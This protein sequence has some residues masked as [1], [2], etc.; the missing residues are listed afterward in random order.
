MKKYYDFKDGL[1]EA[2]FFYSYS[3]HAPIRA[4]FKQENG[5]LINAYSDEVKNFEYASV[6]TR[7]KYGVGVKLTTECD[8]DSFGAPLV[9]LSDDIKMDENGVGTYGLHFEVVAWEKGCNVWHITPV[10][11]EKENLPVTPIKIG[12]KA[13]SIADKSKIRMSVEVIEHGLKIDVN[14]E[15]FAVCHPDIPETFHIGITA[16]EGINRFYNLLIED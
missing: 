3:P 9:V 1:N 7:K 4:K 5:C 14:G 10:Y 12:C 13:F 16:C 2:D 8:F 15:T 11:Y 6:V